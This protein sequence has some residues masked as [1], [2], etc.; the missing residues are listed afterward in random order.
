MQIPGKRALRPVVVIGL[1][2]SVFVAG[3]ASNPDRSPRPGAATGVPD[4]PTATPSL[5]NANLPVLGGSHA[6]FTRRYGQPIL[7]DSIYRFTARN[8]DHVILSLTLLPANVDDQLRVSAVTLQPLDK[9][10]WDD[11]TARMIYQA[12]FPPD[13]V[14]VKDVATKDGTHHLYSSA[15]LAGTFPPSAF[16]DTSGQPIPPGTFDVLCNTTLVSDD[17]GAY[18]CGVRVGW[19]PLT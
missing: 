17:G 16:V 5:V 19:W 12:F 18:G 14:P 9:T 3:C 15:L 8:Y 2:I 4:R 7:K 10:D 6:A 11:N 1:L 13:A